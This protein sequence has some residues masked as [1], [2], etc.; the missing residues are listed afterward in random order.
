MKR[1]L[2]LATGGT[3][4]AGESEEGLVPKTTG[5][6]MLDVIPELATLCEVDCKNILNLDSTNIQPEEWVVMAQA[7]FKGMQDY[8]GIVITHGTDTMAYSAA[9]LSTML[10]DPGVPVVLTGSQLPIGEPGTDAVRNIHDAFLT[11]LGAPAGVY[12]TFGGRVIDGL[13]ATKART[14]GFDAFIS[15]NRPYAG[16]I[17][18]GKLTLSN[19][20]T[21]AGQN[22]PK[23][24]DR[25]DTRVLLFKLIPGFDPALLQAALD[26]GYKGV[27]IESF[28][29]G[30]LTYY[31]RD[32]LP[33]VEKLIAAGVIV[34]ITTQCLYDGCDMTHYAVGIKALKTGVIPAGDLTTEALVIKMMAALGRWQDKKLIDTFLRGEISQVDRT[35]PIT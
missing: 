35:I 4:A 14:A 19:L 21:K 29:P 1:I 3:I 16:K 20:N 6:Q 28:G 17:E 8:D 31:R 18:D 32:L 25:F 26:L 23:L 9:A 12:I 34:A 5:Q 22:E 2:M 15:V 10:I 27:V 11:A 13:Y 30:G 33:A 7:A 24:D